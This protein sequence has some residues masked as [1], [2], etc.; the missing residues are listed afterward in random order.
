MLQCASLPDEDCYPP[1]EGN[2]Q[3]LMS[4]TAY[5]V[6]SFTSYLKKSTDVFMTVGTESKQS[7]HAASID[8]SYQASLRLH[9]VS[10]LVSIYLW[11]KLGHT[12]CK[13]AH[14]LDLADFT[15][16]VLS[17]VLSIAS[18]LSCKL[19]MGAS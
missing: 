11:N 10:L 14:I 17:H 18:L 8:E 19:I 6:C 2:R 5:T 16:V 1:S 13:T 4:C 7:A 9:Q 3:F 15:F 12:S